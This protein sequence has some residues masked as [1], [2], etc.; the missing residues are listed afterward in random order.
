MQILGHAGVGEIRRPQLF[1]AGAFFV[2]QT[3]ANPPGFAAN[4]FP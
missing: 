1:P 2:A 4:N 3:A